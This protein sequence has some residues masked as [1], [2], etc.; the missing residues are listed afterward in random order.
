[1]EPDREVVLYNRIKTSAILVFIGL[2][3][4]AVTLLWD[5]PMAFLVYLVVGGLFLLAGI[6]RF[7]LALLART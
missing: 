1:M 5:S 2:A 6:V 7:I 4:A 3:L